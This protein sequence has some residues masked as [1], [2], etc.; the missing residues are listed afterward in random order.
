MAKEVT[1]FVRMEKA[2]QMALLKAAKKEHIKK[3]ELM[4]RAIAKELGLWSPDKGIIMPCKKL[5]K[6]ES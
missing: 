4:R 5:L 6:K 1:E 3:A 2:M